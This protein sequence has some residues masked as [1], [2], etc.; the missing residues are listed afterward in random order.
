MQ[1]AVEFNHDNWS[2][3]SRI[4]NRFLKVH[5]CA[6][7]PPPLLVVVVV[8]VAVLAAGGDD[9][10]GGGCGATNKPSTPKPKMIPSITIME[11]NTNN[12]IHI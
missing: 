3:R 12:V 11:S 7:P 6:C 8:V 2:R 4:P 5:I 10:P 1:Q 9:A